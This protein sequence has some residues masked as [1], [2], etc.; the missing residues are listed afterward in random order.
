M[1]WPV[2]NQSDFIPD[3]FPV[4]FFN[5]EGKDPVYGLPILEYPGL[6]KVSQLSNHMQRTHKIDIICNCVNLGLFSYRP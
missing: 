3:S 4:F 2:Q 6:F 5:Y 1:Y